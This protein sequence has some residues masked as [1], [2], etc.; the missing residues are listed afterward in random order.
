MSVVK[1]HLLFRLTVSNVNPYSE[2][3]VAVVN[4]DMGQNG[5]QGSF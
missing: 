1:G 5:K 3:Y 2:G 4:G